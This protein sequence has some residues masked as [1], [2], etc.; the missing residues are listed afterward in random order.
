MPFF[1]FPLRDQHVDI[2]TSFSLRCEATGVPLPRYAWFK[3]G[4]PLTSTLEADLE[5]RGNVVTFTGADPAKHDGMY[6]C[7]ASN[8][9][10]T[11]LSSAQVRVLGEC[12]TSSESAGR[13]S[14]ESVQ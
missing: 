9:Y 11:R 5:V 6:E 4:Q 14:S 13:V 12:V 8:V 1:I 3:D 7:S 10:G 2:N